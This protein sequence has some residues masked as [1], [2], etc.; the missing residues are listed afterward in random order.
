MLKKT[1][2]TATLTDQVMKQVCSRSILRSSVQPRRGPAPLLT[3]R[4]SAPTPHPMHLFL[5]LRCTA[6]Q[7]SKQ[8][9]LLG[10]LTLRQRAFAT[11]CQAQKVEPRGSMDGM[12][13]MGMLQIHGGVDGLGERTTMEKVVPLTNAVLV[14]EAA[15]VTRPR[16]RTCLVHKV[17]MHGSMDGTVVEFM[18]QIRLGVSFME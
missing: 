4:P 10:W 16:A 18:L 15:Q 14:E 12:V 7:W 6:A 5:A 8:S 11:T 9:L 13:V 17:E 2:K 3:L 1:Q